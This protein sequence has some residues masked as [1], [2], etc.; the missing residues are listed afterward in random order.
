MPAC[1]A[2]IRNEPSSGARHQVRETAIT[3][4]LL[5]AYHDGYIELHYPRVFEY[6]LTG[7]A[8]GKGY[9]DWCYDEFRVDHEGQ[10]LH[11]IQWAI[12]ETTGSWLI[13]ASDV[14]HKWLP[15]ADTIAEPSR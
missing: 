9:G 13:V 15:F 1:R 12:H 5:G 4:K 11:E 8:L 2:Y 3:I 6:R 7:V 14:E 10:L